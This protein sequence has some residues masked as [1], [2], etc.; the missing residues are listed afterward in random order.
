MRLFGSVLLIVLGV[1]PSACGT[2]TMPSN[3]LQTAGGRAGIVLVTNGCRQIV[4]YPATGNGNVAPVR[5]LNHYGSDLFVDSA[6]NIWTSGPPNRLG[7][8]MDMLRYAPTAT[9]DALPNEILAVAAPLSFAVD[10][11]GYIYAAYGNV[12]EVFAPG[13]EGSA[14]PVRQINLQPLT[15]KLNFAGA[16][17]IWLDSNSNLYVVFT[18]SIGLGTFVGTN[19]IAVFAPGADRDASP[20]RV[21]IGSNTGLHLPTAITGDG[22]GNIYVANLYTDG[23]S[24]ITVYPAAAS[25]DVAPS[26][27]IVVRSPVYSIASDGAGYVYVAVRP[28]PGPNGAIDVFAPNASGYAAPISRITGICG[29]TGY[30]AVH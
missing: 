5:V 2:S 23:I 6:G 12:I 8:F 15:T 17:G 4:T 19:A 21:I 28:I 18:N 3:R 20:M 11:T 13:A 1:L 25:G 29:G 22:I 30:I 7:F 14:K 27:I 26:R 9:D 16:I 24:K 10:A